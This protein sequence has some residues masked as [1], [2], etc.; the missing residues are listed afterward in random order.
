[1]AWGT[2][3]KPEQHLGFE[4]KTLEKGFFESG[5][6]ANSIYKGLGLTFFFRYGPNQLPKFEDNLSLKISYVL[7]LGF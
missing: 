5:L 3:D 2:M 7:D 6:E 4:Y 1:M